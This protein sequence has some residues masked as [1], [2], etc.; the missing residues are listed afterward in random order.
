[1][2]TELPILPTP[3]QSDPEDRE[4][5][6]Y[7]RVFCNRENAPPLRLLLD[8]LKSQGQLPL[9][10]K[11]DPAALE[12]WS[13]VHIS[14]GYN[15]ERKPIELFC[16]RDRGTYQDVFEQEHAQFLER[17]SVFGEVEAQVVRECV[18]GARFIATTRMLKADITEDGY[19]FNGWI[20]QFFQE[21]CSGVVQ[22]D[23]EGFFSPRGELVVE[24]EE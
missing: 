6:V 11:M 16:V 24:M 19:D 9:I 7:S 10:A 22:V 20:L 14:L 12:E 1:M 2:G 15:R 23:G 5:Y 3:P 17:L 4:A 13:W 18:K 21:N 8:Y